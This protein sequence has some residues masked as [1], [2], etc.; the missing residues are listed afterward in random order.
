MK[1]IKTP[2]IGFVLFF[3]LVFSTSCTEMPFSG[4]TSTP[5]LSLPTATSTST[6]TPQPTATPTPA[7]TMMGGYPGKFVIYGTDNQNQFWNLYNADGTLIQELFTVQIPDLERSLAYSEIKWSPSGNTLA[8][9]YYDYPNPNH[10]IMM[11]PDG[12]IIL[13][14]IIDYPYYGGYSGQINWSPDGH[15]LAFPSIGETS[16]IDLYLID[17]DGENLRQLTDDYGEDTSP[18]FLPDGKSLLYCNETI[19]TCRI[20]DYE[21]NI[22]VN[23]TPYAYSWSPDTKYY[24]LRSS[25]SSTF[26]DL[27]NFETGEKKTIFKTEY[28]PIPETQMS[29][30]RLGSSYFSSDG[31]WIFVEEYVAEADSPFNGN[32]FW[33]KVEV[34]NPTNV[35]QIGCGNLV[36]SFDKKAILFIGWLESDGVTE[37]PNYYILS[38][39]GTSISPL[40]EKAFSLSAGVWQPN[41]QS[42]IVI[43]TSAYFKPTPVAVWTKLDDL[44]LWDDFTSE[45][46]DLLKWQIPDDSKKADYLWTVTRQDINIQSIGLKSSNGVDFSFPTTESIKFAS[47]D[48]KVYAFEAKAKLWSGTYQY[49]YAHL[50]LSMDLPGKEWWTE[51]KLGTQNNE[52]YFRCEVFTTQNGNTESEYVTKSVVTSLNTWYTIRIEMAAQS[53][54]IQYYLDDQLIAAYRP[55]DADALLSGVTLSPKIGV[56]DESGQVNVSFDDVRIMK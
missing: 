1:S 40:T 56:W 35:T 4:A 7:P 23:R 32:R 8:F 26:L 21:G 2:L 54:T 43:D 31:K 33:Y 38:F 45:E 13:D 29:G 46:I 30:L 34:N 25:L 10:L 37:N 44:P 18:V 41:S 47:E 6:P 55:E 28:A 49:T 53:G 3:I 19:G 20:I 24:L 11:R 9:L 27:V 42:D 17:E 22:L 36:F 15:W 39:D 5:T 16:H 14:R 50:K 12:T 48:G 51:C 52:P